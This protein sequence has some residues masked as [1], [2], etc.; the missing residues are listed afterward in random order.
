MQRVVPALPVADA[1]RARAFYAESL[2][3]EV[4][5]EWRDGP[6]DPAF[7]QISRA[8]LSLYLS[9]REE[10]G[11]AGGLTY[12]YVSDVD[13]W[14]AELRERGVT[15][16]DEPRDRPW[17]NRELVVSDPDGNRLCFAS[18]RPGVSPDRGS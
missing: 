4:D 6:G 16:L 18:V 14:Y 9:E 3:F 13:A 10:S 2:G 17:G 11:T 5:W 1:G 15:N 7:L 8:G 12:L